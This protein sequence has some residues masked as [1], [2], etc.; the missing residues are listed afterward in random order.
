MSLYHCDIYWTLSTAFRKAHSIKA[1]TRWSLIGFPWFA[2]STL[3][4]SNT[5]IPVMSRVFYW[6]V[7]PACP[8]WQLP[9]QSQAE[10]TGTERKTSLSLR[11]GTAKTFQY[12]YTVVAGWQARTVLSN[13]L[14][15]FL[16][17]IHLGTRKAG[18]DKGRILLYSSVFL[19]R[20]TALLGD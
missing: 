10:K 14:N 15:C 7:Q 12:M 18:A 5:R 8:S 13:L 4:T 3:I 9:R 19:R 20:P 11:E 2:Y 17:S 1:S 6:W 16:A